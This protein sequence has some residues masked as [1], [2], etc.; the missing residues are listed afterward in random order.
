AANYPGATAET[1]AATVAAPLEA[2]INGVEKML[3]VNS[4]SS[5]DGTLQLTVTF[6]TGTDPD[7]ATINVN[8]RVQAALPR[9]P[10]EVRRQG[11]TVLKS[12]SSFLQ[13]ITLSSPDD[14][15]DSVFLSNYALLNIIDELK[16][17]P[18]IGDVQNFGASVYAMR[19]WL[20][21]DK[22][23]KLGITPQD[24]STAIQE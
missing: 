23:A 17:I 21:P 22:M 19:I 5:G 8:N 10:E 20:Q 1:V 18:G 12:S 14:R 11:V 7:L 4:V 15:Y 3:Y 24:V 6:A 13:I 16:R 2:Q 9:L